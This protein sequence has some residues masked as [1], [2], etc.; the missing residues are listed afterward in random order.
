[1][2]NPIV[3]GYKIPADFNGNW[4]KR[5]I[6]CTTAPD[7]LDPITTDEFDVADIDEMRCDQCDVKLGNVLPIE[8][9]VA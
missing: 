2:D 4:S 7:A 8:A 5:C 6:G 3:C 1:M 9:R